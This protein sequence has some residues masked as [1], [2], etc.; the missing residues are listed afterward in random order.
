MLL[1]VQQFKEE[2]EKIVGNT[3][4]FDGHFT[5]VVKNLPEERQQRILQ[6]A[7]D[8]A[9]GIIVPEPCKNYRHL[10][11]FIFKSNDNRL[12]G[13]LTKEKGSYFLEL[14]LDNHK[15]YDEKRKYLGL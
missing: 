10:I 12:R 8:C 5:K 3:I 4:R 6:W 1:E 11:A 15:Y 2:V 14:F 7:R 9:A 13:I